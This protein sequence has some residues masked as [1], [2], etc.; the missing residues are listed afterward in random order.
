[1]FDDILKNP[2]GIIL[3]TGPTGSGKSTT[4]YTALSELNTEDV[5]II[6]VEDPV[7]ANIDGINQVQVNNKA[8]LTFATALRSI[9]RQDPDIIMIGE[10]RDGETAEI[11]V[12]ASITG[13]LVVS[14]LHTN[15]TASS[16]ARLEDMGI[17][18]YIAGD[19]VVGVIASEKH[20][21]GLNPD[22]PYTIYEPCGCKLCNGTGYYG[23]LG[24]Y[25]IMKITPPIKRL[26]SK[27]AGAE[28]IKNQAIKEG[29]NTLKMA[30]INAVKQ[31]VTTIAEMVRATY[32][33]EEDDSQPNPNAAKA[34][35]SD[36]EH[37]ELEQIN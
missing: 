10:I 11:A 23:R 16:V 9:L 17:E 22:E 20:M 24:I 13:H 31:G 27:H 1:M 26:I 7:E 32:E 34:S 15:S 14:T 25:E 12:R 8:N 29:M 35:G 3:V 6:T 30:A 28:E 36:I 4:L 21:L 2:H 19:A 18:S 33:A 37:I 5:N